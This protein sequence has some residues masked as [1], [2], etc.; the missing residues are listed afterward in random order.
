MFSFRFFFPILLRSRLFFPIYFFSFFQNNV[1]APFFCFGSPFFVPA[2]AVLEFAIGPAGGREGMYFTSLHLP[3]QPT[4]RTV[5]GLS[6]VIN[7]L[8]PGPHYP[9]L[10]LPQPSSFSDPLEEGGRHWLT[11]W[12]I[13][14]SLRKAFNVHFSFRTLLL[15]NPFTSESG[16]TVCYRGYV[17]VLPFLAIFWMEYIHKRRFFCFP[18]H[19]RKSLFFYH[20]CCYQSVSTLYALWRYWEAFS[21]YNLPTH[22]NTGLNYF[23][24]L[25]L[26][27]FFYECNWVEW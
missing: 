21:R 23:F 3:V 17:C 19:L 25:V 9:P 22:S 15:Q 4:N 2:S 8:P 27:F 16:H 26:L 6:I 18:S 14:S 5:T 7:K 1:H 24:Y 10:S 20:C 11:G 13:Q 12:W